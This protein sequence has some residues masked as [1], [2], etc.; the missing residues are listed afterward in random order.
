MGFTLAFG[1]FWR[2][3]VLPFEVVVDVLNGDVVSGGVD[4]GLRAYGC[5]VSHIIY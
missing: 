4:D 5:A 1:G 2:E 3:S